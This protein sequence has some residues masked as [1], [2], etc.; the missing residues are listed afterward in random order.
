MISDTSRTEMSKSLINNKNTRL[1]K[2][3]VIIKT[4]NRKFSPDV[5]Y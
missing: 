5:T 2:S 4:I 1:I 3:W